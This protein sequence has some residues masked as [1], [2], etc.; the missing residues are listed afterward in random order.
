M[1]GQKVLI[2]DDDPDLVEAVGI[3]LK[4]EGFEPV[5]AYGG[6]EGLAKA[7]SEKPAVIIL[8]VMMEDKD[9][10]TVAK[11]LAADVELNHIPVIM[12]TAVAEH[13]QDSSYAPQAAIKSLEAEEWFDKPVD[14]EA[15][16]SCIKELLEK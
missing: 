11:E 12:L 8:D 1:A 14:P 4:R 2:I 13:A 16:V 10:F 6:V 5:A 3:L 7:R 9:G 15:L